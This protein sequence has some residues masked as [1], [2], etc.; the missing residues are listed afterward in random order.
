METRKSLAPREEDVL[1]AFLRWLAQQGQGRFEVASRP[2]REIRDARAYDFECVDPT[3]DD[4]IAVEVSTAWRRETAGRE[5]SD[6]LKWCDRVASNLNGNIKGGFHVMT[7]VEVPRSLEAERAA[8]HL[9]AFIGRTD[10]TNGRGRYKATEFEGRKFYVALSASDGSSV[11][12]CR[13]APPD[14]IPDFTEFVIGIV[15]SKDE[16]LSLAKKRGLTTYL[17]VYNTCWPLFNDTMLADVVSRIPP[18]VSGSVDQFVVVHGSVPNDCW[19]IRLSL[20]RGQT[21]G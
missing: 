19:C 3:T 9:G 16:Q 1:S 5:D 8:K 13:A 18:A 20:P 17:V 15:T 2:D 10:W 11:E 14:P 7:P 12:F 6:W 4:R 21:D